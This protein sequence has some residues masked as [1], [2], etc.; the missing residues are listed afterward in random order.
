MMEMG[1]ELQLKEIFDDYGLK[2]R[3]ALVLMASATFPL[4]SALALIRPLRSHDDDE[5]FQIG[6]SVRES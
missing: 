4:P 5:M 2:L 6:L 1:F 3:E